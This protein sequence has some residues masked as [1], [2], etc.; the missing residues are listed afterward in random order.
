[1]GGKIDPANAIANVTAI[2]ACG[3]GVGTTPTATGDY[4]FSSLPFGTYTLRFT[5]A[6]GFAAPPDRQGAEIVGTSRVN[7]GPILMGTTYV[8]ATQPGTVRGEITPANAIANVTALNA[9]GVTAATATPS[10]AG[11]YSLSLPGGTYTLRFTP[12]PGF[13]APASERVS[14]SAGGVTGPVLTYVTQSGGTATLS[15]SNSAQVVSL[16]R[17]R[18]LPSGLLTVTM[19]TN[20]GEAVKLEVNPYVNNTVFTGNFNSGAWLEYYYLTNSSTRYITGINTTGA[21]CTITPVGSNPSRIS[22]SFSTTVIQLPSL[23]NPTPISGTF[24]NVAY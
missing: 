15:V 24:T 11:G 21:F 4:S 10:A 18:L 7:F 12:T 2:D 5:P 8:Y 6:P 19:E 22:G 3:V 23:I 14:V 16:V 17:A 9:Q 13:T 1:L 20:S